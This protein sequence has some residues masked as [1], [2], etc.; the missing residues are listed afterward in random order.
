MSV[1]PSHF[2]REFALLPLALWVAL[3][4]LWAADLYSFGNPTAEEQS[5][6]ELIN[7][8]R[9]N[10]AAEGARLAATTDPDVLKAYTQYAVDLTMMRNEF[11]V[12]AAAQPLAPNGSLTTA[13]RGHSQWMLN[14]ASQSHY[15]TSPA[16]DPEQ[17]MTDAGYDVSIYGENI[18]AYSNS[19]WFGHAGFQVDWGT[20]GTGGMQD[21]RGHRFSIHYADFRE[22]GV[23]VV[24]GTNGAVGPQLVTQD[25]GESF[26]ALSFGTGVA[27]YDLN[28]NNFYDIGEGIAGLT[29]N[30]AGA[31]YYCVTATGGGWAFPIPDNAATRTTTFSGLGINQTRSLVVPDLHNAKADLKL[32]YSPPAV[33]S[34]ATAPAGAAH[35]FSFSAVGGATG[36]K[37]N[38][39]NSAP[40]VAENC[41]SLANVTVTTTAAY[42]VLNTA[43]K[44]EGSGSFHLANPG[45]A[46]N[47]IIELKT[48][49]HGLAT[50]SL[51]FKSRLRNSTTYEHH[52]VQV[53]EDGKS[54]WVDVSDQTGGTPEA[55]FSTRTVSLQQLAGKEFRV[56]FVLS[57]TGGSTYA[58]TGDA[59][60]W[61]IDAIGFTDLTVLTNN[62]ARTLAGTS[63]TLTPAA[64]SYQMSVAPVI[65]GIEFP[66][67]DQAFT[68]A[69]PAPSFST[70][71]AS[72]ESSGGLPAGTISANPNA[73][74]DKDGRP[75]LVEYAFGTS[76]VTGNEATPRM[77]A[78]L[79]NAS[80]FVVRYVRDTALT[81]LLLVPEASSGLGSWNAPGAIGAP[82]GFTDSLVSTAGNLD[83]R[84]ARIP[85]GSGGKWFVRLRVT[86]P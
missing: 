19:V 21:P 43:V 5:Y 20:G 17:R 47:Q 68:A 52:K 75:N 81:D 11:N 39:W 38:C 29:V 44:Q 73:D 62:S 70:W 54:V 13:A 6:I 79:G 8:A 63:G 22:I 35:T 10:P 51:A 49:F 76:P 77:P 14:H 78:V 15:Q 50:P 48:L 33:T 16:N 71:G 4:G 57:F 65:S 46:G 80:D 1:H 31:G 45:L 28:A 58:N 26:Q 25:F 41:N 74:Y 83:T 82:A 34:A 84:E 2:R 86:R 36:Y 55:G 7:R 24:N 64:G 32:T 60:G 53:K 56:R 66:N 61:F 18:Y 69:A 23:G 27:Y 85:L 12:I 72:M 30:V 42:S 9:A 67:T 40:A 37:W 59:Y 3:P